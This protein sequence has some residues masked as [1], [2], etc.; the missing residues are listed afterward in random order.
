MTDRAITI[1][2]KNFE[3]FLES[4]GFVANR[5]G[6]E[7]VYERAHTNCKHIYIRVYTS[8]AINSTVSRGVGQDAIRVIAYFNNDAGK[9]FGIA[10]RQSLSRV[11]RT[12]SEEK[13]FERT[14]LRMREAY[15][16]VNEW[17]KK[18]PWAKTK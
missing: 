9:S 17:L 3:K 13:V 16:I 14:L 10:G 6:D 1:D 8:I 11:Y 12:G 15:V 4:K 7:L 2:A 18:N 5:S